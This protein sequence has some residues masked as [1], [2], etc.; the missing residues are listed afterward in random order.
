MRAYIFYYYWRHREFITVHAD[1][2]TFLQYKEK[3]NWEGWKKK[4]VWYCHF[5]SGIT[6]RGALNPVSSLS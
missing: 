6:A 4:W 5:D 1:V 3:K 2:Y